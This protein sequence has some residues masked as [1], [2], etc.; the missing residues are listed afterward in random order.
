MSASPFDLSLTLG[1]IINGAFF[2]VFFFGVICMQTI[3]YL[4]AF[5]NDVMLI[6]CTVRLA[7]YSFLPLFTLDNTL[8]HFPMVWRC[9]PVP[10]ENMLTGDAAPVGPCSWSIQ[11]A[12]AKE[13]IR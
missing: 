2:C 13:H 7:P 3:S 8:G 9:R 1:P 11:Y 4:K 10:V 6:K 12:S 5:P